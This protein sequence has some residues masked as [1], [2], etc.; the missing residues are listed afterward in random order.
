M[1][2]PKPGLCSQEKNHPP[3][4][5]LVFFGLEAYSHSGPQWHYIVKNKQTQNNRW[6]KLGSVLMKK[7][8]CL[9]WVF[10]GGL[11]RT[12]TMGLHLPFWILDFFVKTYVYI[13]N[14]CV[15]ACQRACV[16]ACTRARARVC[17]CES[18]SLRACLRAWMRPCARAR[19]CVRVC[20][21]ARTYV[22]VWLCMRVCVR[23]C[24]D[25]LTSS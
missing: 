6:L 24:V 18:A 7:I 4:P 22:R 9:S 16:R 23:A 21:R 17:V 13:S 1:Q 2:L 10:W 14:M 8:T 3:F 11:K 19:V 20:A 15:R 12:P 25:V 5:R